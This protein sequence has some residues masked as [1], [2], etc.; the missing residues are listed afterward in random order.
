MFKNKEDAIL[1]AK[2]AKSVGGFRFPPNPLKRHKALP[3]NRYH[4]VQDGVDTAS[5][6]KFYC[7]VKTC[8]YIVSYD[9]EAGVLEIDIAK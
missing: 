3:W 4:E 9:P 7:C 8:T 6:G 5:I 2:M 1:N